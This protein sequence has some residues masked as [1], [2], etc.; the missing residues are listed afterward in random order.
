MTP[1]QIKPE[2]ATWVCPSVGPPPMRG[3]GGRVQIKELAQWT[4]I[5]DETGF[6][7]MESL[8]L[9][10]GKGATASVGMMQ[11]CQEIARLTKT[12]DSVSGTKL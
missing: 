5:V 3:G 11:Y 12:N 7:D 8:N 2:S 6:K 4:E 1:G 9:C 10:F